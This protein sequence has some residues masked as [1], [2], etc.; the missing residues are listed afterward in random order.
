M[1]RVPSQLGGG[2]TRRTTFLRTTT[3][4]NVVHRARSPVSSCRIGLGN[5]NS[6]P[7]GTD[8]GTAAFGN[9][10][11]RSQWRRATKK[12]KLTSF[13]ISRDAP[14]PP[15]EPKPG[16]GFNGDFMSMAFRAKAKKR[17]LGESTSA[18]A[19]HT[20]SLPSRLLS[21]CLWTS[22]TVKALNFV[23]SAFEAAHLPRKRPAWSRRAACTSN[24]A[25]DFKKNA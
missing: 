16:A 13:E 25:R 12:S 23:G 14:E 8:I 18:H 22:R 1:A 19:I 15:G 24:E 7:V 3:E 6:I 11:V 5:G 2:R 21:S 9:T 17:I 10:T 4:K 20:G